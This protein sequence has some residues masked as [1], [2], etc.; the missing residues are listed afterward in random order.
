MTPVD[1]HITGVARTNTDLVVNENQSNDGIFATPAFVHRYRARSFLGAVSVKLRDPAR[2]TAAFERAVRR[3]LPD[4]NLDI[5][6]TADQR[7]T[8]ARV[9]GPYGDALRI[10]A[11]VAALTGLFVVG[12]ALSRLVTS[13]SGELDALDALGTHA[14]AAGVSRAPVAPWSRCSWAP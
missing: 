12:Q 4:M 14:P 5:E 11:L 3:A 10:F 8:F 6:A 2:D 7:A 9:V 13:D 1:F